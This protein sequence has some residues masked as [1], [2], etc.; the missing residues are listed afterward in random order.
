[1]IE[2]LRRRTVAWRERLPDLAFALGAGLCIHDFMVE[3]ADPLR[4]PPH[5][6]WIGLAL[7]A[8]AY[9]AY[10]ILAGGG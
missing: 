9:L 1:M 4:I 6:F 3:C 7:M 5:G 2:R 10:D 8:V